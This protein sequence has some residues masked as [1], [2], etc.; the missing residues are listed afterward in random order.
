MRAAVPLLTVTLALAAPATAVEPRLADGDEWYLAAA[1]LRATYPQ[2]VAVEFGA[3]WGRFETEGLRF[4]GR[5][6]VGAVSI[7][8]LGAGAKVGYGAFAGS[9]GAMVGYRL[10][11]AWLRTW[12]WKQE[13]LRN[14]NAWGVAADGTFRLV[15]GGVGVYVS[16][17]GDPIL[18]GGLGVGF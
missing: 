8:A 3:G 7:G 11:A 13:A 5:G 16:H 18:S 2:V 10:Q 1:N 14:A 17:R 4:G 12:G 9:I 6:W 15:S